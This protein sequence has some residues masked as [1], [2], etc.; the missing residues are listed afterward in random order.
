VSDW[1]EINAHEYED[2]YGYRLFHDDSYDASDYERGFKI[3]ATTGAGKYIP[4][5]VSISS[6]TADEEN[7]VQELLKNSKAYLPLYLLAHSGVSVRTEPFNDPW[8][9][10]QC[11]F[12]V[13]EKD[14]DVDGDKAHLE[15]VL[16]L[17]VREFDHLLRGNVIAWQVTKRTVCGSCNN[18]SVD[19]I[20]SCGG[21]IGFDFKELDSLTNE[22]I[23]TINKHREAE[24]ASKSTRSSDD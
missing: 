16:E 20:D 1:R 13:L 7:H 23:D 12:A 11:G 15:N 2:G 14:S 17:M 3:Y 9:S 18:S 4:V 10:G 24:H 21:Y 22:V 6:E 8:D 5:D 19:V